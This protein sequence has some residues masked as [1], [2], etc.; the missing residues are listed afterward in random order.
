MNFHMGELNNINTKSWGK[1]K[2]F[3]ELVESNN[4]KYE[5][6]GYCRYDDQ[7]A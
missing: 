3:M 6:I 1:F 5:Y 4:V 2:A 7:V